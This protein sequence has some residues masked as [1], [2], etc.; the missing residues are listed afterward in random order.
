MIHLIGNIWWFKQ[1]ELLNIER[2]KLEHERRTFGKPLLV[3]TGESGK[4]WEEAR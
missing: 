3:S 2:A 1:Q 4:Y